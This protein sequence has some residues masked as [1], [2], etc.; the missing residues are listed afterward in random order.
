MVIY[1]ICWRYPI[2]YLLFSYLF[3][4]M[5]GYEEPEAQP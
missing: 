4:L 3:V 1:M 5:R 2:F